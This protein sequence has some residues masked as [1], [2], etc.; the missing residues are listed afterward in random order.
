MTHNSYPVQPEATKF[1]QG[2][3]AGVKDLQ[4][5]WSLEGGEGLELLSPP[6]EVLGY[7]TGAER[8]ILD[9]PQSVGL[10]VLLWHDEDDPVV[11]DYNYGSVNLKRE[12]EGE[13]SLSNFTR[14]FP[15]LSQLIGDDLVKIGASNEGLTDDIIFQIVFDHGVLGHREP[16]EGEDP[17][18][19]GWHFDN[20]SKVMRDGEVVG[21]PE[22]YYALATK[23]TTE[24]YEGRAE[25]A[26]IGWR[27]D[28]NNWNVTTSPGAILPDSSSKFGRYPEYALVRM[29]PTAFHRQPNPDEPTDRAFLRVTINPKQDWESF[30]LNQAR[31]NRG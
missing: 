17:L 11:D 15:N 20:P 24:T 3:V 13:G 19:S 28:A 23:V 4:R 27:D 5:L 22:L 2:F 8:A 18:L 7:A 21:Y 10:E 14:Y 6:S 26:G 31:V 30:I 1:H 12:D 9:N 25:A 29:T 16:E